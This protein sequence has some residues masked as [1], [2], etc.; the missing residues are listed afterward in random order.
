[1]LG[2][3]LGQ[4]LEG[5]VGQALVPVPVSVENL[6]GQQLI[7]MLLHEGLPVR[8]EPLGLLLV[9]A[10]VEQLVR[11]GVK[12]LL[13][14]APELPE[15]LPERRLGEG[16]A[17][18]IAK[19]LHGLLDL[20]RGG[21]LALGQ[22]EQAA[23][24]LAGLGGAQAVGQTMDEFREGP[25]PGGR[26]KGR[27]LLRLEA[28]LEAG[29]PVHQ[30]AEDPWL[31]GSLGHLHHHLVQGLVALL[32][33]HDV[34]VLVA[35]GDAHGVHQDEMGLGQG[36]RRDGLEFVGIQH[37][38]AAPLHLLVVERAAHVAHEED[39][40][41]GLDV[42][43]G[44]DHVHGH[45]DA[46]LEAVA[47]LAQQVIRVTPRAVGDLLA[48]TV[49]P[50][51]DLARDIDDVLGV[52]VILG[53]NKG[54][55]D[56]LPARE[57]FGEELVLEG[58]EHRADL[59]RRHDG[60]VQLL[61]GV[62]LLLGELF[63]AVLAG[64]AVSLVHHGS[65]GDGAA[66]V[67]EVSANPVDAGPDV[68]PVG[69][70]GLMR[71]GA[72]QVLVEEGHGLLARGGREPQHEGVEVAKHVPPLVEDGTVAFVDDDEVEGLD[73]DLRGVDHLLGKDLVVPV[74]TCV[75]PLE[76]AAFLVIVL[77]AVG[78]ALEGA[79]Q[80]LDRG[81]D[82]ARCR[83]DATPGEVLDVIELLEGAA[84]IGGPVL[85]ELLL[86]LPPEVAPVHQEEHPLGLRELQHPV[87]EGHGREGLAAARGHLQQQTGVVGL[88]T[89]LDGPDGFH[90]A[91]AQPGRIQLGTLVEPG[92]QAEVRLEHGVQALRRVEGEERPGAGVRIPKV[93][94]A[95]LDA[96]AFVAKGGN[97]L[98]P[99]HMGREVGLVPGGLLGHPAEGLADRLGLQ[100]AGNLPVHQQG[101]VSRPRRAGEFP[102][103]HAQTGVGIKLLVVLERPPGRLQLGVD[104]RSGFG[105]RIH[106][107][108]GERFTQW[109]HGNEVDMNSA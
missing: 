21:F 35:G 14:L 23:G 8:D 59:V 91:V 81:D 61:A 43:A 32:A 63:L 75:G 53:K 82:H 25:A 84:I 101:V 66:L 72:D 24:L 92:P 76:G 104:D 26:G 108:G 47:E 106:R 89:L 5:G 93:L 97:R 46:R 102:D 42:G 79:E 40:F 31:P 55:R 12:D 18:L 44:G 67:R 11:L 29:E 45:G 48:E 68:D 85:L 28:V 15:E 30:E 49:A 7:R 36:I 39:A 2:H 70:G 103:R 9:E 62:F 88:Q 74:V 6:Q 27:E 107:V 73:G 98:P 87:A 1:M 64:V 33:R 109:C 60:A 77:R 19:D 86:G 50:T 17:G 38:G 54:F 94:E 51:E 96:C 37:T 105:F 3:G 57:Q 16:Q 56:M 99:G 58:P 80:A 41:Q 13:A 65:G 10:G 95:C 52:V 83:I 34:G 71:I 78:V 100:E 69:H 22:L 4:F 20:V 90:L